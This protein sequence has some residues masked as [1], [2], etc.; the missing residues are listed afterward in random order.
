MI[1]LAVSALLLVMAVARAAWAAEVGRAELPIRE[2]ILT[3]GAR[4]YAIDLKVGNATLAAG[5]DT[6]SIGLRILPGVLAAGDAQADPRAVAYGYESGVELRGVE[7]H[8][9]ITLGASRARGEVALELVRE[10]GCRANKPHCPSSRVIPR[11]YGVEGDGLP[12]QGF[13]AIIGI[14]MA[15]L[16]IANPLMQLGVRRWIVE[17]PRPGD[18]RPGRLILNPGPEETRAYVMIPLDPAVANSQDAG[19]DRIE[20]WLTNRRSGLRLHGTLLMDTGD[21]GLRIVTRA[22]LP[23]WPD[24][25]PV[26]I[27]F[28]NHGQAVLS[29]EIEIGRQGGASRLTTLTDP[30]ADGPHFQA[31]L[32][33]YLAFSVLYDPER[34]AIG[35]RS[36]DDPQGRGPRASNTDH[37]VS[38]ARRWRARTPTREFPAAL[39][40]G[41]QTAMA[42]WPGAM[43]RMPPPTPLFPG[44]PTRKAK[45]PDAS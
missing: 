41:D 13:P 31:G 40:P 21:P 11:A 42:P 28:M 18:I 8:A 23:P 37:P 25:T 7:G 33:P 39:R 10:V 34:H 9:H 29:T 2:I 15:S 43:A 20:A 32:I 45:S 5:L 22:H 44:S 14:G 3:D 24:G 26:T 12:W 35:L 17:L 6:G 16:P 1:R 27:A 4:R 38:E 30:Q 36:R 19:H